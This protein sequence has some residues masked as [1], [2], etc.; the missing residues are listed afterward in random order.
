M[1]ESFAWWL[2]IAGIGIG[3][4][5]A[6]LVMGRLP[7]TDADLREEERATEA[8]WISRTI[9][10]YGGVAPPSLVEE[11]LELHAHYLAGPGIEPQ[12]GPDVETWAP[13]LAS[14]GP[15]SPDDMLDGESHAVGAEEDR[16]AEEEP[17][18][19]PR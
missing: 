17:V 8:A 3:I 11:V 16:A 9:S 1:N 6:W 4:A 13:T 19:A 12:R 15:V 7:R 5:I 2:L 14:D 18:R 10:A